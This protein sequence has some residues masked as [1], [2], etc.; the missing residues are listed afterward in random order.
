MEE[1]GSERAFG[2][3][4]QEKIKTAERKILDKLGMR[5]IIMSNIDEH[6]DEKS[7]VSKHLREKVILLRDFDGKATENYL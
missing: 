2:K 4:E 6:I 1:N 3:P 5:A 7:R